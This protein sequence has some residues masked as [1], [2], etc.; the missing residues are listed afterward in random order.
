MVGDLRQAGSETPADSGHDVIVVALVETVMST[1]YDIPRTIELRW[2]IYNIN[3][4][5]TCSDSSF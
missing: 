1:G 2:D 4:N 5:S 3:D